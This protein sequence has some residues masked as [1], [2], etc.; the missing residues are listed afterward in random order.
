MVQGYIT[1]EELRQVEQGSYKDEAAKRQAAKKKTK[2][3]SPSTVCNN[4]LTL[5]SYL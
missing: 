3:P 2:Q 5:Y 1:P 4:S